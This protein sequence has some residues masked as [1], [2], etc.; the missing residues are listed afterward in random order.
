MESTNELP[1]PVSELIRYEHLKSRKTAM[2]LAFF[3]TF[4][5]GHY[6]YLRQYGKAYLLFTAIWV[7]LPVFTAV[8][9][10]IWLWPLAM[11]LIQGYFTWKF[12]R[13]TDEQFDAKYNYHQ[14]YQNCVGCGKRLSWYNKPMFG[15]GRLKED[16][17]ICYN[18]FKIVLDADPAISR[19]FKRTYDSS[20][21]L[22][23]LKDHWSEKTR[24]STENT[25]PQFEFSVQYYDLLKDLSQDLIEISNEIRS[26]IS[27]IEKVKSMLPNSDP[28]VFFPGC[29]IYDLGQIAKLFSGGQLKDRNLET[30]GYVLLSNYLLPTPITDFYLE[31]YTKIARAHIFSAFTEMIKVFNDV[32]NGGNPV[33]IQV[34][35]LEDKEKDAQ[36]AKLQLLSLP[37]WLKVSQSPHF[38]QYAKV[39]YQYANVITKADGIVTENETKKLKQLYQI[40]HHPI[41]DSSPSE[42]VIL[43]SSEGS[44]LESLVEELHGMIGLNAVKQE[45]NSLVNYVKIQKARTEA[46]LK[47]SAMSYHLVF[48]GNP[49][50]GKTTVARIV[51]Q[52]YKHLGILSKGHLVETDRAGLIAEYSGQ[53][54]VKVNRVV[55]SALNGILF[56]D[57]A[58]SL[59]GENKDDFGKEAVATLIKRMEDNRDKLVLII[60]GY[61][62]E[63]KKFI[64]TNPGF[65]S[66]FNKYVEFP[67]YTP[68]EMMAIFNSQ[69][70]KLDFSLSNQA[71]TKLQQLI[72]QAY[73]Q[74]DKT[75]GNGRFVR[76]IFE[77]TLERQANR[78]AASAELTRELLTTILVED[79]PDKV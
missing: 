15:L 41:N 42:S 3:L 1:E 52:I 13:M 73:I 9:A 64:E 66:R 16:K 71:D 75:F 40:I 56:I 60:A 23:I 12:Y 31:D 5:G 58:Y 26:D 2:F 39:L 30:S 18:C 35:S 21:A 48:T 10:I 55:D 29:I 76:N 51:A 8:A 36:P 72:R 78:I 45:I 25:P 28:A 37:L 4:F 14:A 74:R 24:K 53:T 69:S 68:D 46:G 49:G 34:M 70:T 22:S 32:V 17:G 79:I 44:S 54:A 38:D 50:T 27:L 43:E 6:I 47:S 33:K 65:K 57:E 61:T 63:M 20:K 11:L 19:N 7:V 59:V 62:N 77:K 67:D